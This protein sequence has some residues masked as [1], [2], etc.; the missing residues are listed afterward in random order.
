MF[1]CC[2]YEDTDWGLYVLENMVTRAG[3]ARVTLAVRQAHESLRDVPSMVRLFDA[4]TAG[5]S[6][7]VRCGTVF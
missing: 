5:A 1:A 2:K 4:H 6:G 7:R 3:A